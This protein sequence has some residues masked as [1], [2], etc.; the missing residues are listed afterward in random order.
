[1]Q[2]IR[3]PTG[4]GLEYKKAESSAELGV[5]KLAPKDMACIAARREEVCLCG[6]ATRCYTL[7]HTAAHCCTLQR[8]ATHCSALQRTATHCNAL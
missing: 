2:E 1:M 5:C 4:L 6:A 8:T 7:Q 3:L